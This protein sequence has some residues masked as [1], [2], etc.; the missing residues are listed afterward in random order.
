MITDPDESKRALLEWSSNGRLKD[1]AL[2]ED[3]Q[4]LALQQDDGDGDS[5]VLA[6]TT[7]IEI[8]AAH[9]DKKSCRYTL[10]SVYLQIVDPDQALVA[11]RRACKKYNVTDAVSALD[12]PAVVGYFLGGSAEGGAAAS[13]VVEAAAA[14]PAVASEKQAAA[15]AAVAAADEGAEAAEAASSSR[16]DRD[17]SRRH[18]STKHDRARSKSKD[19]HQQ[20]DRPQKKPKEVTNEQLFSNLNVVVDKRHMQQQAQE[21]I[22][23]ALSAE[24]FAVTPEILEEYKDATRKLL[25]NEIP[26][27]NSSSILRAINPKKDLSR[28]LELYNEAVKPPRPPPPSSSKGSSASSSAAAGGRAAKFKKGYLV[29]KKPVIVVPKGMTAPITLINAHEFLS[30]GKFVPR[31]VM[32][33]QGRQRAPSTTF[34]RNVKT[35]SGT[36]GLLEYEIMDNPKKLGGDAK[37][38]ERI[39]AVVVLG[40]PWQFKDWVKPYNN[41]VTLFSVTYG[42]YIAMEGD[43]IP[44]DVEHGWAVKKARLNRDKRG[45]DSVTF[46]SFWNGLDEFMAVHRPEL[47]PQSS[48]T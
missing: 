44:K 22:T 6:A 40:Q 14:V 3:G 13:E 10:A 26:V 2:S 35:A 45:L 30:N 1:G 25:A 16:S 11:Y 48:E 32:I 20:K 42:F 23:T 29:G 15:D 43:Q 17:K 19:R 36:S 34:T 9:G 8:V 33:K 41:P 4:S 5:R 7:P 21:E 24:G 37:E 12:K 47:L 27:G 28:V 38:W 18:S 39:V 31:D 46:A